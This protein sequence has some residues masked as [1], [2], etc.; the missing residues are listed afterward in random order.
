MSEKSKVG[1]LATHNAK[2]A[3]IDPCVEW[4]AL[5]AERMAADNCSRSVAVD[6]CLVKNSDLWLCCQAWDAAQPKVLLDG[7][8]SGNWGNRGNGIVRRV[9]RAP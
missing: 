4:D 2:L 7:T 3:S 6:R 9:P 5:V 1:T 8:K